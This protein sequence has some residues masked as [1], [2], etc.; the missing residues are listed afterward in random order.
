HV[1]VEVH[2]ADGA[3]IPGARALLVFLDET[4]GPELGRAGDGD[5]P[6]V[7]E[8]G[9]IGVHAFAK[10]DFDVIDRMDEA[11]IHL[12]LTT[13]YDAHGTGLAD[14]ALVV[15]VDVRAHGELGFVLL[16]IE[17]LQDLLGIGDCILAAL[18]GAGDRAG[19][20]A[21]AVDAH[22]HFRRSADQIF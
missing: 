19:F 3:A 17:Q 5:R 4:H 21:A 7:A 2:H 10:T 6:G 15:A 18:D 14:A 12:D 16:G 8:E 13:A 9:V 20:D 22:E 11:R 1:A